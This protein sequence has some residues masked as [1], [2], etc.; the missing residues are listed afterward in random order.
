MS[1]AKVT[2][3]VELV[4]VTTT[5]TPSPVLLPRRRLLVCRPVGVPWGLRLLLHRELLGGLG[6]SWE[7]GTPRIPASN[8]SG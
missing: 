7:A 5:E 1:G 2:Q 8:W 4:P 3:R 6:C